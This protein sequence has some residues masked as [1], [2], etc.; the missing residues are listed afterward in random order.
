MRPPPDP[1]ARQEWL[2]A[3]GRGG[4]ASGTARGVRTRRYH[5]LLLVAA[6]PPT[7]RMALVNGFDA[8]ITTRA[9]TFAISSQRYTPDVIHPDGVHRLARFAS[10]PWPRWRYALEDGVAI[11]QEIFVAPQACAVFVLWRLATTTADVTLRVRPFLSGRRHHAL[12]KEN[13][14]FRF[15]AQVSG[16]HV[17]WHPYPTVPGIVARTNAAYTHDPR[18]YRNFQYD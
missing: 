6:T 4:Y 15:D 16:E 5:A 10:R 18:W 7:G 11:E 2:E 14:A 12:H 1:S 3:D 8:C 17:A 13:A 9:G